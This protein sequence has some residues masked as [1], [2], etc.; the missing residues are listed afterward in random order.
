MD[1]IRKKDAEREEMYEQ[2]R[3]FIEGMKFSP[4]ITSSFQTQENNSVFNMGTPTNLQTPIPSQPGS[5]NWQSQMSMQSATPNE[6]RKTIVLKLQ[7]ELEA[8]ATLAHQLLCNLTHYSEEMRI[9]EIQ[10]TML[11]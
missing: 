5:S 7:R 2:M 6:A 4:G 3:N 10:M 11:Q 9:H 1:Q 8:E